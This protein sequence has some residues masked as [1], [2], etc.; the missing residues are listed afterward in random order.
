MVS[1]LAR[2]D[3]GKATAT[4]PVNAHRETRLYRHRAA[5]TR[6]KW[7]GKTLETGQHPP[8]GFAGRRTVGSV[9]G[10]LH[11]KTNPPDLRIVQV[12]RKSRIERDVKS[13]TARSAAR[14]TSE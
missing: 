2:D 11:A 14:L 1:V 7:D 13:L 8:R 12:R 3:L 4:T 9:C 5:R 10:L 6:A